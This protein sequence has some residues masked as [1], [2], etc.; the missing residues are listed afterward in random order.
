MQL[1]DVFLNLGEDRFSQLLRSVSIGKLRT[2]QLFE[3]LKFRLHLNKLN[4][5]SLRKAAPRLF[6]RLG[7]HDEEFATDLSQAVLVSH[8]DLIVA[9]LNFLGIPHEEGFFVKDLDAAPYLTGGWEARVYEK[10]KGEFPDALLLF[11]IN[12]LGLEL[13]KAEKPFLPAAA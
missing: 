7:E 3:R 13:G 12:H 9:V 6:A 10:F 11:Y 5:E 4:T 2:Y 8:L 1:S